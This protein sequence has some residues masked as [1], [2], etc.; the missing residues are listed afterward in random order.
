MRAGV[1]LFCLAI[2]ACSLPGETDYANGIDAYADQR[3]TD[4]A[5]YLQKSAQAGHVLGMAMLAG[6]LL[7]GQGIARDATRAA[8]WYEKAASRGHADSQAILGLLYVNGIG[9]PHDATKA[10]LWLGKAAEQGD[11][12]SAWVLE[13]LVERGVMRL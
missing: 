1:Y 9:V 13:N 7:K 12:Q 11:K 3:F 5:P 10:R 2:A 8:E 6:M 4:A